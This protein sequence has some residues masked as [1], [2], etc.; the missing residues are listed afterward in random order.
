VKNV[1][2]VVPVY[3]D[4]PS[5]KDCIESLMQYVSS[6]HTV[7]LAN[8][9]GP[10]ADMIE[11]NI[12]SLIKNQKNFRYHRNKKNLGFVQNCN[13]AV[14]T[15]DKTDND[16]LLLN[17]DTIVTEGFLEEMQEVLYAE[18]KMGAVSPRSNNATIATTPLSSMVQ[19]GIDPAKSYDYFKKYHR[20]KLERY[21]ITP[22]AHGF[23]ML[24]RRVLIKKFG[25]FDEA[26]GLGYG[27]EV[28][29]C[30]RI[31]E[32]G[33][34]SALSNW[35]Y[36]FH[37]EAKSFGIETK[38]KLLENSKKIIEKRYPSYKQQVTSYINRAMVREEFNPMRKIYIRLKKVAKFILG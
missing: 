25:L 21:T 31:A 19:R 7:I 26:F 5:L 20:A 35:S 8:D 9:C 13:N 28:D 1:T 10:E 38:M 18:P 14:L 6:N 15:I 27:E 24:I 36:V 30:M 34:K 11:A 23:C 12:K 37:M 17:S 2:V 22:V 29:F 33:Y 16:I 32:H 3:G 4:W